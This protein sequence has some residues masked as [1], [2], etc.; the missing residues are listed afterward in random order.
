MS[1][2]DSTR[3]RFPLERRLTQIFCIAD[4]KTVIPRVASACTRRARRVTA[5]LFPSGHAFLP[6]AHETSFVD[7]ISVEIDGVR[8]HEVPPNGQGITVLLALN[9][10]KELGVVGE[11]EKTGAGAGAANV[12]LPTDRE[13]AAYWHRLIEALRLA[14]AD[15]RWYCAD[16]DK[17]YV[18][19]EELLGRNYAAERARLIDPAKCGAVSVSSAFYS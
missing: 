7:P 19:V 12:E 9:I 16:P 6:Q 1:P 13:K 5:L 10:L 11:G 15:T 18:P 17:V 14:F 8:V 4:G 3:R 2:V